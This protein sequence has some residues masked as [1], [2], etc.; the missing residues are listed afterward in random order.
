[1]ERTCLWLAQVD[2]DDSPPLSGD[3]TADVCVVG[4]GYSGL[5]TALRVL[6]LEPA[7][8]VVLVEAGRCGGAA[9]GRNGGFALSWWPK[10]G[11]LVARAG[12]EEALRLA[13]A[14]AEAIDEIGSC[15]VDA[16]FRRGGWI[17]TATS[18]AQLGAWHAAVELSGQA[19]EVLDADALAAITGS[20]AHVG[21]VR[22]RGAA[23][24]HPAR[25]ARGLRRLALERGVVVH[26]RTP[27][28]ELDRD[29]GVVRTPGGSV[30]ADAVVLATNAWLA[31]MPEL[32]R[33]L[34]V[35]S[36]DVV[37][38]EPIPEALHAS[39]WTGGEAIS[40]SRLM[41]RYWRTDPDGRVV[42]GR[43]G[44]ALAYGA[45]FSFD[46]PGERRAADVAGELPRL[47]PAARGAAVEYAWGGAVDRSVDGLPFFGMLPGRAR[48]VYGAGF[49]GNGVGPAVIGGR[50]MAS[51][52]LRRDDEWSGC[53]L[54]RGVP[55]GRFPPE[56]VRFLGGTLVRRAVGRKERIEDAGGRADPVT[57]GLA[58]LAPKGR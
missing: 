2:H 48:V 30:R 22:E 50:V 53:A 24:V 44:G 49:S 15:G 11:S 36:S 29:A 45:R 12:R 3:V 51:L 13:R 33:A 43:G 25:L 31:D 56:P 38:T 1:M 21:G 52:A 4:G 16:A 55:P 46:D 5:W 9:S 27:M 57:R 32:R 10:L 23:T 20:P 41:V 8:R 17:W 34:A 28:V 35:V 40:D 6:S 19:F 58:G 47:V 54:A 37:A 42:L 18:A 14:S 39:G 7:A 26:E